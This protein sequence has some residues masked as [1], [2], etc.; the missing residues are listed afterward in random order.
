VTFFRFPSTSYSKVTVVSFAPVHVES[1][2]GGF[3]VRTRPSPSYVNA[4][5]RP[6]GSVTVCGFPFASK[7]EKA[8]SR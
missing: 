8:H 7:F 3:A 5:A 1:S 4:V 2:Q 6:F